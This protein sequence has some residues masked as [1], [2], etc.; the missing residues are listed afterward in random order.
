LFGRV[1]GYKLKLCKVQLY[2]QTKILLKQYSFK[3]KY[4][5]TRVVKE[6]AKCININEKV[7]M[8]DAGFIGILY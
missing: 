2:K 1:V 6:G 4:T 5:Y 8:Y 7:F 3:Y